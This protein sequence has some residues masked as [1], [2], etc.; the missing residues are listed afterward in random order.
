[1][2]NNDSAEERAHWPYGWL[3]FTGTFGTNSRAGRS[4]AIRTTLGV[5]LVIMGPALADMNVAEAARLIG[6]LLVP[7]GVGVV[8]WA[9]VRYLAQLDELHRS[10]QLE[11]LALSYGFVMMLA[12]VW[13]GLAAAG[14][15]FA[16]TVPVAW[17]AFT[18]LLAE[19]L[20]GMA[21]V[22]LARKRA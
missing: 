20:R 21:L 18:L 17:V 6:A 5:L 9:Y 8:V 15:A 1:M 13:F 2:T 3:F 12:G 16:Q 14:F 4:L 22:M 19:P 7:V 11:A 10:I